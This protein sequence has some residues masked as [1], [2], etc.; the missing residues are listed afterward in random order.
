MSELGFILLFVRVKTGSSPTGL[1]KV[2][3]GSSPT[4]LVK[5]KTGSGPNCYSEHF[6]R[7]DPDEDIETNIFI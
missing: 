3:T 6:V 7:K 2:K 1:V 5:V 4:G